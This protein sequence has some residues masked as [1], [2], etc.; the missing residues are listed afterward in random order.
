MKHNLP[1]DNQNNVGHI[2]NALTLLIPEHDLRCTLIILRL[3]GICS[4]IFRTSTFQTI[5]SKFNKKIQT[6]K[7]EFDYKMI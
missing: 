5:K 7:S 6:V 2:F 4:G 1:T 3:C